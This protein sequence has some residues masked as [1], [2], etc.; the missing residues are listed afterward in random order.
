METKLSFTESKTP[1]SKGFS[2]TYNQFQSKFKGLGLSGR[3]I[4]KT[5]AKYKINEILDGDLTE[6]NIKGLVLIIKKEIPQTPKKTV[7]RVSLIKRYAPKTK[8]KS[9]GYRLFIQTT[10]RNSSIDVI[11]TFNG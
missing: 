8:K 9:D 4:G 11:K 2:L 10:T 3:Q 6:I 1:S 5:W 7:R